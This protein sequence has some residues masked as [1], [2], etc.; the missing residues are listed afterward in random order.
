[1]EYFRSAKYLHSN[2]IV[3]HTNELKLGVWYRF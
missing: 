3:G 2:E 1:M